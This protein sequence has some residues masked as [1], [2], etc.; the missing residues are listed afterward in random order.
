VTSGI[1]PTLPILPIAAP[2]SAPEIVDMAINL[3][4]RHYPT[5]LT[6]TAVALL[7]M[8][9]LTPISASLP[10]LAVGIA[11]LIC[12]GYAEAC[13]LLGIGAVYRG[14]T[15]PSAGEQ[16][17]AGRRI[18]GRV[19]RITIAR[20]IATGIGLLFLI[21]PG[22]LMYA[23][24]LLGAPAAALEDLKVGPALD[25]GRALAKGEHWRLVL[26]AGL[27]GLIYLL[28]W[29]G[30][31]VAVVLVSRSESFAYLIGTMVEILL[32]PAVV[33]ITVLLYYDVRQR[34]EGWDIELALDRTAVTAEP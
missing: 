29:F 7:P 8:L 31:S 4:R 20:N 13:L 28:L 15:L 11:S 33:A 18:A 26:V 3:V 12:T 1:L 27:T 19:I 21:V 22:L 16:L 25:R 9:L 32:L 6:V 34:R 24:Y 23:H 2:R 5:F 17:R 30:I 14:E 10:D